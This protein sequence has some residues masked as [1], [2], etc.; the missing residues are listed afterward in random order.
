LSLLYRNAIEGYDQVSGV[1]FR[2]NFDYLF[3]QP[4]LN[5]FSIRISYFLDYNRMKTWFKKKPE[6]EDPTSLTSYQDYKDLSYKRKS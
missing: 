6:I 2:D 5:S 1:S 4:Q 3:E